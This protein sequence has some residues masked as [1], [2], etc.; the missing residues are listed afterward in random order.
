MVDNQGQLYTIEGVAAGVL[1]VVTA[2][3]VISSSSV[4]TPQDVH[5]V[6]MQLEQL[7]NDALAVLDTP[8][9]YV[10]NSTEF[11]N[12]SILQ[13]QI[14]S[15][16]GSAFGENFSRIINSKG[17]PA[18]H[19]NLKFNATIFYRDEATGIILERP[20]NGSIYYRENAVK[21]N[22]WIFVKPTGHPYLDSRNQTVLL[23]VLL[24]RG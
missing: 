2:Y 21:V 11:A 3:L 13:R 9:Q 19:D 12:K 6:D 22:R 10:W 18:E 14:E 20:L 4:L 24:W 7:G 1:M 17:D 8:D 16:G 5:I 23:E 15:N